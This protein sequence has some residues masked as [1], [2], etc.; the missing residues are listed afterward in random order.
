MDIP[1]DHKKTNYE[2]MKKSCIFLPD[3][4]NSGIDTSFLYSKI[5]QQLSGKVTKGYNKPPKELKNSKPKY[6]K[7][8]K[9]IRLR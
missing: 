9:K 2:Q 6:P 1:S 5:L 8:K 4:Y 3:T 7:L